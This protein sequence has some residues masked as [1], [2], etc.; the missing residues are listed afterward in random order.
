MPT[1]II[2]TPVPLYFDLVPAQQVFVEVPAPG[3]YINSV[4]GTSGRISVDTSDPRNP[5]IDLDPDFDISLWNDRGN[6]D[7]SVNLYPSSGGSGTAGA[8]LKGDIWTVSV[9][10]TLGST[11]VTPG[12]TVRALVNT[13]GQTA[14]NW[15]IGQPGLGYNPENA[16]NKDASG[17]YA[18]LTLFKINFKNGLNTFTSFFTNSNTAARTY[19]FQ[20]RNGIIADDT[21]LASRAKVIHC[22]TTNSSAVTGTVNNTLLT[23]K[24]IP[25]G[26]FSAGT[27]IHVH[28]RTIKSG[29]SG[30][31]TQRFYINTANNLSGA[32]LCGLQ[33]VIA[34][35]RF[36]VPERHF[37][38]KSATNTEVMQT[39][40][41]SDLSGGFAATATSLNIDWTIDQYIIVAEQL[42]NAADSV[43]SSYFLILAFKS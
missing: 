10:G 28:C 3:G 25:A 30:T 35:N 27:L 21:D 19:T 41:S 15:A 37:A 42:G 18:G 39:D 29:A 40:F 43:V 1:D 16:A 2:V 4:A 17:G 31:S 20:D 8:V 9:S 5:I 23:S 33:T 36:N 11:A 34:G 6:Y 12:Y 38:I 7:A 22:D 32:S 13:P 26:T 24:L 14:G